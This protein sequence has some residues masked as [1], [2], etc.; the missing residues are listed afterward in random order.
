ML[1][2]LKFEC[3]RLD[4]AMPR[5]DRLWKVRKGMAAI[6]TVISEREIALS[7]AQQQVGRVSTN[8]RVW[9]QSVSITYPIV[10]LPCSFLSLP[11]V[12]Y[13]VP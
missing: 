1:L 5:P 10:G 13:L 2:T 11:C 3:L 7:L 4:K 6:K 8:T 9:R 12:T